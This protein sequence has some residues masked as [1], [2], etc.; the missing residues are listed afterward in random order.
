[1]KLIDRAG[2]RYGKAVVIGRAPNKNEH[3]T[4]ARWFC[5]CDCGKEFVTYGQDLGRNRVKSCGCLTRE[6]FVD[7]ARL[8]NTTHGMSRTSVYRTWSCMRRRC[9]NPIDVHYAAYGGRGIAV[10]E[11]W[12][13]FEAFLE[14]MGFPPKGMSLDRIDNNKGYCP[15]NCRWATRQTQSANRRSSRRLVHNGVTLT[16]SEWARFLGISPTTM[17]NRIQAG[18]PPEKLFAHNLRTRNT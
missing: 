9:N 1:M 6:T 18:F 11:R 10:C 13:R 8:A 15:E 5:R 4:N 17:S 14:D 12:D 16:M 3:D 7:R 2:A